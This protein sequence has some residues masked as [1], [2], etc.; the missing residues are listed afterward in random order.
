MRVFTRLSQSLSPHSSDVNECVEGTSDCT[1]SCINRDGSYDCAC[2]DG[3]T[4]TTDRT[5][6]VCEFRLSAWD[7]L[8]IREGD[9]WVGMVM[10]GAKDGE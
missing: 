2:F 4:L 6:C 9:G 8:W 5:T 10:G 3:F 7:R 1:Q